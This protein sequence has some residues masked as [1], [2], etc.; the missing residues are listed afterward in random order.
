MDILVGCLHEQEQARQ[1]AAMSRLAAK[2]LSQAL[3]LVVGGR[4]V[5]AE[6]ASAV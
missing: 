6:A 5:E 4:S 2:R 1:M 3:Q